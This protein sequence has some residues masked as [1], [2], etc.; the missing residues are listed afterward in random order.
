MHAPLQFIDIQKALVDGKQPSVRIRTLLSWFGAERRGYWIVKKIHR[1]L[2]EY[3]LTTEPPFEYAYI[4]A[5][6]KFIRREKA[7]PKEE[8]QADS[9]PNEGVPCAVVPTPLAFA[10]SGDP[11]YR[12]G[13]LASANR[14]PVSVKPDASVEE[15]ITI[16]LANDFSQLPV[17]TGERSVKGIV[18]WESIGTRVSLGHECKT[19]KECMDRHY[20]ISADASLFQAITTVIQHGCVLIRDQ[21]GLYTGMV[22]TSDLSMQ[23]GQLG[24][25]FLLLGEIENHIRNLIGGKFTREELADVRDPSDGGREIKDVSDL[26]FGE[27]VRLF[28]KPERWGK[29]GLKFDRRIFT[30]E[31]E[32]IRR[33]RNEVMHFD[34][35][36]ISEEDLLTLRLFVQFLQRLHGIGQTTHD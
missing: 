23:F 11:T 31:L 27:Y 10:G 33:I 22:T 32:K 30:D 18:S 28:Q 2:N 1:A 13:K 19:A 17:M 3:D 8:T 9:A 15:A 34:P 6:V 7:P 24:E 29:L 14:K 21:T 20:D 5:D 12:I 16:M 4:D 26:T 35:D 36:G 25:P